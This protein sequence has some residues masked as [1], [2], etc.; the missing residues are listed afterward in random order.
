VI[1]SIQSKEERVEM[2]FELCDFRASKIE[3]QGLLINSQAPL[4]LLA[5]AQRF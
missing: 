2:F 3:G 4:L 5:K 1:A